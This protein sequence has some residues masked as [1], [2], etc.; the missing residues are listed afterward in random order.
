MVLAMAQQAVFV[1]GSFKL[2][3]LVAFATLGYP[4]RA[5][6]L[7]LVLVGMNVRYVRSCELLAH[8]SRGGYRI[9][10]RVGFSYMVPRV[11]VTTLSGYDRLWVADRRWVHHKFALRTRGESKPVLIC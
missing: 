10:P 9:L 7:E 5:C 2:K 4:R 8:L 11:P 1:S 6:L 3:R